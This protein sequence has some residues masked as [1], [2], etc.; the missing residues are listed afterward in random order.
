MGDATFQL[1]TNLTS[2]ALSSSV[3]NIGNMAFSQCF[4]LASIAISSGV[5]SIGASAFYS[6]RS[7]TSL[8]I[9]NSVTSIGYEAFNFC[10]GLTNVTISSSVTFIGDYAFAHCTSL[11]AVTVDALNSVYSSADGVLPD[12]SQTLLIQCPGGKSGSYAIPTSVTNITPAA[13]NSCGSLTSVTIPDSVTS[14]GDLGFRFCTNLT[15]VYF[16]GNAPNLGSSVFFGDTNATV[17]YLPGATGW[18]ST[19]GGL[20]TARWD[21]QVQTSGPNF[22]VRTNQFGFTV[23]W[24]SGQVVVVDACMNLANPNWSPLQTN[25]LTADSFYFSDPQWRNSPARFYRIRSP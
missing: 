24:T 14:I 25:T 3:T 13:F 19:F 9:P 8:T 11:T 23:T 21:P 15:G 7:L 20:P 6:C 12:K 18:A 16:K 1:C 22:G 10:S 2:V 5:T 17:Y 4:G